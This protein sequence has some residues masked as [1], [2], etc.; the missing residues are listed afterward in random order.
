ML[1]SL[2]LGSNRTGHGASL[3]S[4]HLLKKVVF[5]FLKTISL[6]TGV[7]AEDVQMNALAS[8]SSLIRYHVQCGW[9][10]ISSENLFLT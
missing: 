2:F 6:C 1:L 9:E 10:S 7:Y 8:F 5:K 3:N 4:K